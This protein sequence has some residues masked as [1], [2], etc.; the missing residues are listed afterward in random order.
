M[1]W[2]HSSEKG[3]PQ[4]PIILFGRSLGGAVAIDLAADEKYKDKIKGIIVEN[5]FTSILDMM[6][7]I[8]PWLTWA[9]LLCRNPWKSMDIVGKIS[10]PMLFVSSIRDEMVPSKMMVSLH[11]KASQSNKN[12]KFLPI[13]EGGH[14]SAYTTRGY[15][16]RFNEWLQSLYK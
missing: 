5:T 14:M 11:Q 4:S 10:V 8:V 6:D 13:N 3:T 1:D 16:E 12:T 9:K 2:L 15:Y 7:H